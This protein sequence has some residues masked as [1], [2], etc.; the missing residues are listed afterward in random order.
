MVPSRPFSARVMTRVAPS[1]AWA[2]FTGSYS[3]PSPRG[4]R[5]VGAPGVGAGGSP[6]GRQD[7]PYISGGGRGA[8]LAAA[9][10]TTTSGGGSGTGTPST[11]PRGPRPPAGGS[12]GPIRPTGGGSTMAAGWGA[13]AS[14]TAL[15]AGG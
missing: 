7:G 1:R 8:F 3:S 2:A 15:A 4:G 10:G 12:G 9:G 13:G 11:G 5:S 6:S 14:G